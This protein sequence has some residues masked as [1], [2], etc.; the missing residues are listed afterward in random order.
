V[1]KIKRGSVKYKDKPPFKCFNCG[2]V[3]HFVSKFPYEKMEDSDDE[4]NNVKEEHNNRSKPYRHKKGKYTKKKSFYSREDNSSF[5]E[6]DGY[7][8]DIDKE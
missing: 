2:R 5:E 4:D 1:R 8:Y 6:R 3:G 7:V